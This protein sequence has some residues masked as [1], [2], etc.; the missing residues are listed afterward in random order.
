V[1]IELQ[2][3]DDIAKDLGSAGGLP[4]VALESIALEG[5]RTER[6]SEEQIRRLLGFES[7]FE[8][9]E[10]LKRHRTPLNYTHSDLEHDLAVARSL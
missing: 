6:L 3:P 10:F 9:H 5:Y 7:R 1:T 2:L 4:R 8:V